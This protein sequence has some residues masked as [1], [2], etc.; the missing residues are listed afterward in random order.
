[1]HRRLAEGSAPL[2]AYL[3]TAGAE[4]L[5][6]GQVAVTPDTEPV[7]GQPDRI[8]GYSG[9][10][11]LE[12]RIAADKLAEVLGGALD[13]GGNS[14]EGTVLTPREEE[15][16]AARQDLAATATGI[17]LEQAAAVAGRAGRRLGAIRQIVVDPGLGMAPR[18]MPMFAAARMEAAPAPIA[19]EA[20]DTE[21]AATVSVVVT[22]IEP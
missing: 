6:T 16:D 2:L 11:R 17:A 13:K 1:M 22:L 5:R 9:R 8:T 15:L 19:T 3:R 18:P 21:M 12:F 10:L 14:L 20:G 7:R 4:R